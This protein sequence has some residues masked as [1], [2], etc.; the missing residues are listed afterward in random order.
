MKLIVVTFAGRKRYLEILF[1]YILK[2]KKYI[3][4][5]HLYLATTNSEDIEFIYKFQAENSNFVR[6]IAIDNYNNFNKADVWNLSYRNCLDENTVYLKIDDDI[7]FIDD[8]LFTKFIKYREQSDVP[9]LFPHIINNIISSPLLEKF[10]RIKTGM[11]NNQCVINTWSETISRIKP[12]IKE[13]K[14]KFPSREFVVTSLLSQNEILCPVVWGSLDYSK[15]VHL[16]FLDKINSNS[17]SSIY[18]EDIILQDFQ[19]ISIQCCSW[20]GRDL[21]KYTEEFGSVGSEDEPW[22]SVYLP[23]WA[24]KPNVIFGQS[25][26]SHFSSYHQEKFL[27][28]NGILEEYKNKKINKT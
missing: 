24:G 21:K 14:G 23:I 10:D 26:V 18:T 8:N 6:V 4:E 16:S 12:K 20:L 5:Y 11:L 1:Q 9:V 15:L 27:I 3:D 13:L 28:D 25:V 22:I 19:P 7:V 2:N 17:V